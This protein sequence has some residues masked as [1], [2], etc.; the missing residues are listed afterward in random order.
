MGLTP[1][2]RSRGLLSKNTLHIARDTARAMSQENVEAVRNMY[3]PGDPSRF[4]D[5]LD[6]G[7]QVD[8]SKAQ[9]LPDRPELIGGKEA[10]LDLYRHYWGTWDDY[11]LEP[12]QIIEAGEDGVV[13]VQDE[14][15]TG[16]GSGTPFERRWAVLYTMREARIVRIEHFAKPRDAL[17]AAGLSE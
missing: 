12:V 1:P 2:H 7:V 16:R 9:L 6:E 10:A 17:E 14:R 15:G 3:R 11:V 5:L 4:F 8:T 13:V